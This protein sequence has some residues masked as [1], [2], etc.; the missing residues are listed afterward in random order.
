MTTRWARVAR[1]CVAAV[2]SVFVAL[3]SHL[4]VGGSRPSAF[5]LVACVVLATLVCVAL[6]GKRMSLPRLSISVGFSQ[7]L[8]HEFFSLWST[9]ALP[10]DSGHHPVGGQ[11][12]MTVTSMPAPAQPMATDP[13]MWLAHAI[14]AV[15]TIAALLNGEKAFWGL[16]QIARLW[17]AAL[18][19]RPDR[20]PLPSGTHPV[21]VVAV[22]SFLPRDLNLF[23]SSMRHRGP[24]PAFGLIIALP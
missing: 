3:L 20:G 13:S 18:S 5:A 22:P 6:A 7:F 16:F 15:I 12:L 4:I 17:I 8:F 19:S 14:A 1:G 9:S 21:P 10:N 2:F 11:M 23:L 24:P